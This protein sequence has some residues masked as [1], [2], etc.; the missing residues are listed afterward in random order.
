MERAV[1]GTILE[2]REEKHEAGMNV[3][4]SQRHDVGSTKIEVNKRQRRD[5][6]AIFASP[7]LK[8]KRDQNSRSSKNVRIRAQKSE[9]QRPKSGRRDLLLYFLLFC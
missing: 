1:F 7:S 6:N 2:L 9:Q 4:T 8:A 3:M 5:V